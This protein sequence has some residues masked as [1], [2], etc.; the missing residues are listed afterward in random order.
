MITV[1][2]IDIHFEKQAFLEPDN[3]LYPGLQNQCYL[4]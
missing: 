4:V 2:F 1:A 3:S